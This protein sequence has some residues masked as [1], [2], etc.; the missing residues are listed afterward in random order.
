MHSHD[1][2]RHSLK[3]S[4]S[5]L[6]GSSIPTILQSASASAFNMS[7]GVDPARFGVLAEAAFSSWHLATW[8]FSSAEAR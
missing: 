8:H 2:S 4:G 7:M 5:S 3:K 1:M 6:S